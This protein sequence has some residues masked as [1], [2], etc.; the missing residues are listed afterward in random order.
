M[1]KCIYCDE[2]LSFGTDSILSYRSDI[3]LYIANGMLKL[4]LNEDDTISRTI[5]YCPICG[6]KLNS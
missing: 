4:R 1:N 3:E 2:K 5:N 6:K